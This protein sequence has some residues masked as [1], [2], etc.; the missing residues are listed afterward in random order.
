MV[1]KAAS[2]QKLKHIPVYIDLLEDSVPELLTSLS[3][4]TPQLKGKPHQEDREV[5]L[6]TQHCRVRQG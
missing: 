6:G 4:S 3:C 5:T 1:G 2:E